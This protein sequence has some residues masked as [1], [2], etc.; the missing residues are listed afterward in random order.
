MKK[1]LKSIATIA[2]LCALVFL[3]GEWPE[4]TPRKKVITCDGV[5]FGIALAS[6]LYLKKT[7]D[8]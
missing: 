7:E 6:G 3:I 8:E 4:K 2:L 5:A 1:I